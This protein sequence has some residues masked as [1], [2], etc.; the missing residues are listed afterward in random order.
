MQD[1]NILIVESGA[2]KTTWSLV[3][4][5]GEEKRIVTDGIN[6]ST[7]GDGTV[8]SILSEAAGILGRTAPEV[9]FYA[10]GLI[11]GEDGSIPLSAKGVDEGL[12][13]L[14][15]AERIEYASDLLA[16]ARALFRNGEGIAAILGT[17]SNSGFYDGERIVKGV[18]SAGFILGDEGSGACLGKLFVA[19]FLKG[20]MPVEISREF[21]LAFSADYS[22]IVSNVYHGPSPSRY[23][24]SFAPW[25]MERYGRDGYVTRL[26]ERNITDFM[27]RV[28]LQYDIARYEV[29]VCGGYA[30]AN[31]EVF[32]RLGAGYGIR[33][34][35]FLGDPMDALVEYHSGKE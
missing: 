11:M 12:R 9:H 4:K 29:G 18:R 35:A 10:A 15:G 27:E 26:V 19:D 28:L 31:R 13:R 20:L 34:S 32:E 1:N 33:F 25:I 2:T 14:M 21:A 5:D 16:A 24:G 8:D 22:T 3:G 6:L 23:L 30:A 17:G 7:T